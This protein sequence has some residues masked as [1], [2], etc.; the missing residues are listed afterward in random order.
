MMIVSVAVTKHTE[1]GVSVVGHSNHV[2]VGKHITAAGLHRMYVFIAVVLNGIIYG[3][4]N[5]QYVLR[6][7]T[8]VL[9]AIKVQVF[10]MIGG[11]ISSQDVVMSMITV[12]VI[13]RKGK[14]IVP[15]YSGV[16]NKMQIIT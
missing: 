3:L 13:D 8:D 7:G 6:C 14:T 2:V 15:V 12:D 10:S 5:S 9:Q 11:I 1:E 16:V 4:L